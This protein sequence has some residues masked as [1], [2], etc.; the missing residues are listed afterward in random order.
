ADE[1]GV[2]RGF[3]AE[4][5]GQQHALMGL[6]VD[7]RPPDAFRTWLSRQ[8][9]PAAAPTDAEAARG[10]ALFVRHDCY[11]CHAVRGASFPAPPAEAGPDLTHLASRRTLAAGTVD[12]EQ[13]ILATWV[14]D[15]H[16]IK[17][18][19]R[20]PPTDLDEAELAALVSYL[21]G[22]R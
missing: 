4:F 13:G 21:G 17:P 18:G 19:V 22:L 15:P 16:G 2:Y 12:N 10:L 20:M 14:L 5:C 1:P 6:L 3:C 7:A 8:S 9:T 11:L